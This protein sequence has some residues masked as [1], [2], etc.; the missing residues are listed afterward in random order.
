[1]VQGTTFPASAIIGHPGCDIC[2]GIGKVRLPV[3]QRAGP[4]SP[5]L[6]PEEIEFSREYPCPECTPRKNRPLTE[7]RENKA[8]SS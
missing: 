4:S 2:G 6:L 8:R 3:I 5:D 7:D 1:M